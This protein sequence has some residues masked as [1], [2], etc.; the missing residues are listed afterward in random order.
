MHYDTNDAS[1]NFHLNWRRICRRFWR[2][3]REWC[4]DAAY[5]RYVRGAQK[6]SASTHR[7]TRE[8][9]Y[10]EQLDRRYS[11]PNRCC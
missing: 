2:G 6:K 7:M 3:L 5:E 10:V 1:G 9:F 8:E 11:H 4:G